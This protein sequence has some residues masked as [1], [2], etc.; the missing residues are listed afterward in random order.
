MVEVVVVFNWRLDGSEPVKT[1][2][3]ER[4]LISTESID[5]ALRENLA[6]LFLCE[7][8]EVR[9]EAGGFGTDEEH[10]GRIILAAV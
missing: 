9:L 7:E 5:D 1:A 4:A 8:L 10:P 3:V 2:V 6:D